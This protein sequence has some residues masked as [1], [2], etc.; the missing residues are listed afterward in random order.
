[1]DYSDAP[2]ITA[3]IC[4]I[5]PI[6]YLLGASQ[7]ME[8]ALALKVTPKI[9][10][11]RRLIYCGEWIASHVLHVFFLHAPDFLGYDDAIRMAKD[12]PEVVR[13]A[14]RL[15]KAGN[16][17][18]EAIGG[19]AVHPVNL[20]VGGF[21]SMPERSRLLALREELEWGLATAREL[22]LLVGGFEFPDLEQ[23]Y[24]CVSLHHPDEYAIAEGRLVSD[25]GLD[26]PVDAFEQHFDEEHVKYS[27]ALHGRMKGSETPYLVGPIARYN[28]NFDQLS[29]S[30]KALAER[31]GLGPRVDNPFKSIVVRM[32]EVFYAFEEALRL[33]DGWSPAAPAA[34]EA[35]PRAGRGSGCT[36]APRGICYHRYDLDSQGRILKAR[37]VPPTS[38]NQPQMEADLRTVVLGNLGLPDD[39]LQWLCEQSIRNYDPC[40]SCATHFLRLTVERD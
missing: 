21:Y 32:V 20:R 8:S 4:G 37:I 36:E 16:A 11:L 7:A 15:K 22:T 39:E 26:I 31:A 34:V 25:R 30:A 40:I 17:L 13:K 38:Q 24:C 14:L 1:R 35:P 2:D 19:R 27:N 12:H 28:N 3:R 10:A 23:D 33:L 9:R 6:A 18:L 29:A 5:C